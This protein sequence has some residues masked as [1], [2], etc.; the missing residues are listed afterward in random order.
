MNSTNML[1]AAD[2]FTFD[3]QAWC[4]RLALLAEEA[5]VVEASDNLRDLALDC[6]AMLVDQALAGMDPSC[7]SEA[8]ALA[9]RFG[10]RSAVLS[11]PS[12]AQYEVFDCGAA[13][14]PLELLLIGAGAHPL[15]GYTA[16]HGHGMTARR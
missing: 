1:V 13:D 15:P 11:E 16:G 7:R 3:S 10:Y 4:V 8:T 9:A 12:P 5:G 14:F 6:F 2:A